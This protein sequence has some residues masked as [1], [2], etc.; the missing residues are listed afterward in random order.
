M[1]ERNK[2][3]GKRTDRRETATLKVYHTLLL[4]GL[5]RRCLSHHPAALH[6]FARVFHAESATGQA[7][8]RAGD[9]EKRGKHS[10][11][12]EETA[13]RGSHHTQPAPVLADPCPT[14]H[15]LASQSVSL[16]R[17]NE[18]KSQEEQQQLNRSCQANQPSS[19]SDVRF[20]PRPAEI[21]AVRPVSITSS[22]STAPSPS[23]QQDYSECA[24][25]SLSEK[26]TTEQRS[27]AQKE[28]KEERRK[29]TE[30]RDPAHTKRTKEEETQKN[31]ERERWHAREQRRGKRQRRRE[32]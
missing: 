24:S 4:P 5:A 27:S 32:R 29:T 1:K 25:L 30:Q 16:Q 28:S 31:R 19:C 14:H 8:D 12:L 17:G 22:P 21:R 7:D 23:C 10:S 15:R 2:G 18:T 13:P 6:F 3:R 20:V 9:T 11:D 26:N